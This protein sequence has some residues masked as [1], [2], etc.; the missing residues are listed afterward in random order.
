MEIFEDVLKGSRAGGV[1]W[2]ASVVRIDTDAGRPL[3]AANIAKFEDRHTNGNL[4]CAP[5][6]WGMAHLT[7]KKTLLSIDI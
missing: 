1:E 3:P 6:G 2:G 5:L 7:L 4:S